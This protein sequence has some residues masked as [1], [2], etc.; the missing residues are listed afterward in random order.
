MVAAGGGDRVAGR[1]LGRAP[2]LQLGAALL[3]GEEG[4]VQR[5]ARWVQVGHVAH[6]HGRRAAL[7]QGVPQRAAHGC[8][9]SSAAR[10]RWRPSPASRPSRRDPAARRAGRAPRSARAARPVPGARP[11]TRRRRRAGSTRTGRAGGPRP[12]R[13]PRSPRQQAAALVAAQ[14]QVAPAQPLGAL[15]VEPSAI[16]SWS[17][18]R[19][20]GGTRPGRAPRCSSRRSASAP[21]SNGP[22]RPALVVALGGRRAHPQRGLGDHAQRALGPNQQLAQRRSRRRGGHVARGQSVPAGVSQRTDCTSSSMRP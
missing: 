14:A 5:R 19:R 3:A 12:R 16:V 1:G 18:P 4:E 7:G 2:L 11:R 9:Y 22:K 15:P 13:C 17:R 6:H 21:S 10:S 20:T 8:A